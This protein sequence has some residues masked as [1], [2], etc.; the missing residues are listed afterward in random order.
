[1][2]LDRQINR[3]ADRPNYQP[4][5]RPTNQPTDARTKGLI[6]RKFATILTDLMRTDFWF[7]NELKIHFLLL[8]KYLGALQNSCIVPFCAWKKQS[9]SFEFQQY[10]DAVDWL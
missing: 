10:S 7:K 4:A 5:D 6:I 3:L 1:M 8:F 9:N 2:K